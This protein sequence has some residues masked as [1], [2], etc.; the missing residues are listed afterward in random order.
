MRITRDLASDETAARQARRIIEDSLAGRADL[1]DLV[2][3]G[4]ELA[5]NAS[6]YGDPPY[7]L[8][9]EVGTDVRLEVSNRARPA[10]HEVPR[11]VSESALESGTGRL[12]L[13]GRGLRIV[14]RLSRD[15]GWSRRGDCIVVWAEVG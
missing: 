12:R 14:E 9:I 4:S 6:V 3:I 1:D 10:A 5:A 15:W 11:I 13:G 7:S 2:I 8:T